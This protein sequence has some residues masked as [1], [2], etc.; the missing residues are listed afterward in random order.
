MEKKKEVVISL[1]EATISGDIV[2]NEKNSIFTSDTQKY[3]TYETEDKSTKFDIKMSINNDLKSLNYP[4]CLLTIKNEDLI[5]DSAYIF[6]N[7]Y[8]D[9]KNLVEFIFNTK[10]KNNL[11]KKDQNEVL[12]NIMGSIGTKSSRRDKK[13][14]NILN[15]ETEKEVSIWRRI[16]KN[17]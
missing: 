9:L 4:S 6:C 17:M 11:P 3:F 10:V 5:D 2:W 13:I 15:D 1:N 7:D 8:V 12:E 16:F 14:E